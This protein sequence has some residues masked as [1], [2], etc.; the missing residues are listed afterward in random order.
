MILTISNVWL[1]PG[2]A[3]AQGYRWTF[4]EDSGDIQNATIS[5]QEIS[6]INILAKVQQITYARS[7]LYKYYKTGNI[8]IQQ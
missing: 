1:Y 7:S 2:L 5:P 8:N 3:R 6:P 4:W